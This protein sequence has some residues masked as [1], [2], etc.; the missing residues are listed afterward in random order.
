MKT[1]DELLE[2]NEILKEQ[3]KELRNVIIN[4]YDTMCSL[5]IISDYE[6]KQHEEEIEEL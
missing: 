4:C 3:I 6:E 1:Y 5:A 2:E